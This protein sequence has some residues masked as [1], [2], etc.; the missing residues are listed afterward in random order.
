[1][2]KRGSDLSNLS[3]TK[4]NRTPIASPLKQSIT[5]TLAGLSPTKTKKRLFDADS[6]TGD[7]PPIGFSK[8]AKEAIKKSQRNVHKKTTRI[9]TEPEGASRK[10]KGTHT[11][12]IL[13]G[14]DGTPICD[15]NQQTNRFAVREKTKIIAIPVAEYERGNTPDELHNAITRME[16]R[17]RTQLE[18]AQLRN[19]KFLHSQNVCAY[20]ELSEGT[21]MGDRSPKTGEVTPEDNFNPRVHYANTP[22]NIVI[23][24]ETGGDMKIQLNSLKSG[25]KSSRFKEYDGSLL[26]DY[27]G[28]NESYIDQK[29]AQ[30]ILEKIKFL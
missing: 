29:D 19:N 15:I 8:L 13:M 14:M 21:S 16:T 3:I 30:N 7:T 20:T 10:P 25:M 2:N 12:S 5:S 23:T 26:D 11:R 18:L 9:K 27:L 28:E 17:G 1:M 4:S 24:A 6:Y 22:D